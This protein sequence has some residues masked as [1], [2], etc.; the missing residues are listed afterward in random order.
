MEETLDDIEKVWLAGG[1]KKYIGGDNIS[2]ADI[3]A[4]CE[5]EQPRIIAG[6]DLCGGR[7][8]LSGYMDRVKTELNPHYDE[9]HAV[10]QL[11]LI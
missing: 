2:V 8:V 7:E 9:V 6:Y 5:L 4:C 11:Y 3:M 1:G 10:G